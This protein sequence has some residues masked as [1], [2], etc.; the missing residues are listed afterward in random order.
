MTGVRRPTLLVCGEPMRGDDALA[1]RAVAALPAELLSRVDVREIGQL[2]PDEL[3]DAAEPVI[4]IDAVSGPAP[5]ELVDMD[6]A[7]LSELRA[8][9]PVAA[10]T[11]A[12][13]LATA[14]ALC[15]RLRGSAPEGRFLGMGGAD[16]GIGVPLS[17]VVAESL[18]R[19]TAV[20]E[21]WIRALSRPASVAT[22]ANR[23]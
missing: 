21:D 13:P 1:L 2:S 6:L 8:G 20:I 11:H 9:A 17:E 3:L 15:V 14:V 10:S 18:P 22:A 23:A 4:V 5:G 7:S 19:L 12:L 16:Y